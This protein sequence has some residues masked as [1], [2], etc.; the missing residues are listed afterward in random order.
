[1]YNYIYLFIYTGP[2]WRALWLQPSP[3]SDLP[4]RN[5]PTCPANSNVT[6]I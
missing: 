6:V 1:M 4:Q 3:K 2:K 5:T